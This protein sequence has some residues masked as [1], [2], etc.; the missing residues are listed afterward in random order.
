MT[1]R[2]DSQVLK[3]R[4]TLRN[5]VEA[6]TAQLSDSAFQA[7]VWPE[8]AEAQ[9][10]YRNTIRSGAPYDSLRA[11]LL[12]DS[13]T[14]TLKLY[15]VWPRRAEGDTYFSLYERWYLDA[16]STYVTDAVREYLSML[17]EEQERPTGEDGSIMIGWSTLGDRLARADRLLAGNPGAPFATDLARSREQYLVLFLAGTDNA[18]IFTGREKRLKPEVLRSLENFAKVNADLP[19]AADVNSFLKILRNNGLRE[20]SAVKAYMRRL[21][22]R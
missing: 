6:L 14:A 7:A 18:P 16:A 9:R 15:G 13:L 8:G 12:A 1:G 10:L 21:R 11:W 17:A 19:A 20:T 22:A 2:A 5:R 4:D 3:A